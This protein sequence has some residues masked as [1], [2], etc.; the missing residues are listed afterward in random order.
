MRDAQVVRLGGWRGMLGEL[1]P[2]TKPMERYGRVA[3]S[4]LVALE[5]PEYIRDNRQRKAGIYSQ[6]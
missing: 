1:P 5:I 2:S 4:I 3:L 6:G